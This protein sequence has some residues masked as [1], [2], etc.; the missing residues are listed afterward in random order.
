[1]SLQKT[2][3]PEL[4]MSAGAWI[5]AAGVFRG[6]RAAVRSA[7]YLQLC[8]ANEAPVLQAERPRETAANPRKKSWTPSS[9]KW[10]KTR[11]NA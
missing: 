7:R 4:A 6:V 5:C 8:E 10:T 9:R 11:S 1:M 2:S 3:L